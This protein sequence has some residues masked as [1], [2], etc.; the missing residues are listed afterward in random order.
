MYV[1]YMVGFIFF[2]NIYIIYCLEL[3]KKFV[4]VKFG[5]N[6]DFVIGL[7]LDEYIIINLDE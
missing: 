1:D 6:S 5:V 4:I 3:I 2:W 7:F